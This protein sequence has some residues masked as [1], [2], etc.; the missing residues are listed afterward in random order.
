M[1][2]VLHHNKCNI[3]R[4]VKLKAYNRCKQSTEE[5]L[6]L[7]LLADFPELN[8]DSNEFWAI[9]HHNSFDNKHLVHEN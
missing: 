6:V 3:D 8:K 7:C 5:P 1:N 4:T 2:L 9:I